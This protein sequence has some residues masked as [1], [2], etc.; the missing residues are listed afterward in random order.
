MLNEFR[1]F[2]SLMTLVLI[3]KKK[4][5][6]MNIAPSILTQRQKQLFTTLIMC[7]NQSIVPL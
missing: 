2:E 6:K 7:L 4:Q 1:G 5:T 3:L